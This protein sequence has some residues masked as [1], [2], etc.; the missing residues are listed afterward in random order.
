MEYRSGKIP[1]SENRH[2]NFATEIL[3][4]LI[5]Y[6]EFLDQYT[7]V[8]DQLP[9]RPKPISN[10]VAGVRDGGGIRLSKT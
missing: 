8:T 10:K 1:P 6:A 9:A 2:G 5:I 4:Q 7:V 3:L